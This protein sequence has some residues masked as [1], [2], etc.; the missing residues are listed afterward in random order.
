MLDI[1]REKEYVEFNRTQPNTP[2]EPPDP[3]KI[4]A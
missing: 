1:G 3:H 2:I 4:E